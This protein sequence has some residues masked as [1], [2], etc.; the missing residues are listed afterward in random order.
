MRNGPPKGYLWDDFIVDR[1]ITV[2]Q[3]S[4]GLLGCSPAK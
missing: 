2:G 3:A 1:V 4:G